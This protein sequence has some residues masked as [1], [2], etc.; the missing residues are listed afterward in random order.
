MEV[1]FGLNSY[2]SYFEIYLFLQIPANLVSGKHG[3]G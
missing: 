3:I 1:A 2:Q